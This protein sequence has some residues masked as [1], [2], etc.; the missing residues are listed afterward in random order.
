MSL[1][2]RNYTT[3]VI[4]FCATKHG[5]H[6]LAIIFGLCGKRFAEIHGNLS[7]GERQRSLQRFQKGEADYLLATDLAARG[8]D[9]CNV[10]TVINFHLPLDVSRYIHRVGRTARMGRAGRAVTVYTSEEYAKVKL[11]G[12]QC[13]SK[14][15]STVLK[16]T[17]APAAVEQWVEK[18]SGLTDDINAIR[19][20]ESLERELRLADMYT[21]K[22]ENTQKPKDDI[23]SRPAKSWY[24]TN[25]EKRELRSADAEQ[26][27]K[28]SDSAA[29]AAEADDAAAT[30]RSNKKKGKKPFE[31]PEA[32]R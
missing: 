20:D 12:K 10:E 15:K 27:Q 29:A 13:R 26:R 17:V 32:R 1:V 2:E 14:V 31:E 28:E 30:S 22:S 3:R 5:A 6:R 23:H 8:L 11:L 24:I 19:E 25:N 9:L 18:I 21:G 4:I 16:R 7:Q